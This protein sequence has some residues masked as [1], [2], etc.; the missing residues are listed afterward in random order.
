MLPGFRLVTSMN[1]GHRRTYCDINKSAD[2]GSVGMC[3]THVMVTVFASIIC[4]VVIGKL[5]LRDSEYVILMYVMYR[6]G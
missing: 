1:I 5:Y 4:D 6:D 2:R 3:V